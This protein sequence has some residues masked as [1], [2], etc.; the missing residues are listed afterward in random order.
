MNL[1]EKVIDVFQNNIV[2][3]MI[4]FLFNLKEVLMRCLL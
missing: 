4:N 1:T 2:G 3:G